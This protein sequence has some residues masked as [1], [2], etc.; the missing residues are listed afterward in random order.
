MIIL[1]GIKHSGKTTQGKLLAESLNVPFLDLDILIEEQYSKD[2]KYSFRELYL[3]LGESGFR[4][5]ETDAIKSVKMNNP[6]VLALGGG[7]IDNPIA[8]QVVKEVT[9]RI[10]LDADKLLLYNRIK[11]N[12]FPSFLKDSPEKLFSKLFLRRRT[13]Y[14]NVATIIIPIGNDSQE[15]LLHKI[16][17]NL[18]IYNER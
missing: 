17:K 10:F 8:M 13:L 6:G 11:K 15:E 9:I 3:K 7:T 12:G 4:N 16:L 1:M 18:R 14:N 2:R 5:L